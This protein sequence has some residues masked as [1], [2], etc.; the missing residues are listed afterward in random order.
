VS[1]LLF[2]SRTFHEFRSFEPIDPCARHS[3]PVCLLRALG[4]NRPSNDTSTEIS[5]CAKP[6]TH[7]QRRR[8]ADACKPG[9]K[10]DPAQP[11]EAD[12][13]IG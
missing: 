11:S 2:D 12:R 1:A 6:G 4:I 13:G 9:S 5:L 3:R 7:A 10:N 8:S